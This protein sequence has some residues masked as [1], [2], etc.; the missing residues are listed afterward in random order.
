[1]SETQSEAAVEAV[2]P[3]PVVEEVAPVAVD[4][5]VAFRAQLANIQGRAATAKRRLMMDE[6]ADVVSD[7]AALV[8]EILG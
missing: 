1:M 3:T 7:L 5:R 2:D 4:P 8:S 6:L